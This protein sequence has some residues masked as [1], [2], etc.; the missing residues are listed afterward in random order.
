MK[1]SLKKCFAVLLI[2]VLISNALVFAA[3]GKKTYSGY[4]PSTWAEA[5]IESLYETGILRDE[6]FV[7]FQDA[8]TRLE[9]IYLAVRL[10][11]S[12]N[13]EEVKVD[14]KIKFTDTNDIYA[15]K[16]ATLGITSGI[17]DGKFGPNQK[18]TRE[19]I[20]RKSVV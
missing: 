16:G 4:T 12:I 18:I 3:N 13:G 1:Y 15:L 14:S 19:Q 11:E 10:Y 9:F 6:A 7:R 5:D 8:I 2:F 17:G 20:D